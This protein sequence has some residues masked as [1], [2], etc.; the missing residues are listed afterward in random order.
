MTQHTPGPWEYTKVPDLPR[1]R[2]RKSGQ[3]FL[4]ANCENSS[5]L[6]KDETV[7]NARLI[8]AA[9]ELLTALEELV[10]EADNRP[11]KQGEFYPDTGGLILARDA[12]I[13]A[14][15]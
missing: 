11:L 7:A 1:V 14:T 12:I 5:W 15:Q 6:P 9:P 10:A 3:G 4:I 8:A 13:K 2:E